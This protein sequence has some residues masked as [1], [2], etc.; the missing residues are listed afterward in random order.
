VVAPLSLRLFGCFEA[1]V[2]GAPLPALRS[3]R[4]AWLLALLALREGSRVERDWLAATLWP[5]SPR[6]GHAL[7]ARRA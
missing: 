6:P 2:S 3:R 7:G 5:D 1:R 4:G